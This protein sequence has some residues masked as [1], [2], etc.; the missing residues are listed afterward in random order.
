MWLEPGNATSVCKSAWINSKTS[1][2][3]LYENKLKVFS[4]GEVLEGEGYAPLKYWCPVLTDRA[5]KTED[6]FIDFVVECY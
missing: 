3:A 2:H 1:L 4:S 6:G 5:K